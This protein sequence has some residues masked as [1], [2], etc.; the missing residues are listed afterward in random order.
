[1]LRYIIKRLLI[2]IPTIIVLAILIFTIVNAIPGDPAT[3]ALGTESTADIE[4]VRERMGLNVSK[5]ERFLKWIK[6]MLKGDLGNSYFLGRTVNKAIAERIPVTI[7]LATLSLIFAVII[8]MPLG[9]IASLKPNSGRDTAIMGISLIGI[10][11]PEFFLGL[12]MM[13][14]FALGLK[15]FPTGGYSPLSEGFMPWLK[16]MTLPAFSYGLS[17]AAYVARLMRSSMLEVLNQD[18]IETA[19]SKGQLET[20]IVLKHALRNA[21]LPILTALGMVY[22]LLLGGAFITES[23]FR[24][25]GAGSLIISSIKKRDFPVVQG[26]LMFFSC[27][28]LIV[29]LI[30]DVLYA[31]VDPRVRYGKK[32]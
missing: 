22:A 13:F 27:A 5:P 9:I 14:I 6:G 24:L 31:V 20:I 3:I 11:T 21:L 30:V 2:L 19:R 10:S 1:M 25:P 4:E 32:S 15:L 26:A 8:G 18:Y 12:I 28:I 7:S 17:Q 29:N 16:S 23:L